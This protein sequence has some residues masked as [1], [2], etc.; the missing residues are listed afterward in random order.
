MLIACEPNARFPP[1]RNFRC[2]SS[3][4][5]SPF[6]LAVAISVHRCHC[7]CGCRM[8]WLVNR[9]RRALKISSIALYCVWS[10]LSAPVCCKQYHLSP[11]IIGLVFLASPA[12]YAFASPMWG[13]IVDKMVRSCLSY[14]LP[15]FLRICIWQL[16]VKLTKT[17]N[18]KQPLC[19]VYAVF[20]CYID[21]KGQ[22]S[23]T[24]PCD[25]FETFARFM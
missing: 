19:T 24:N 10:K 11:A 12:F 4:D 2:H 8:P 15:I 22:L 20:D 14:M 13:W 1:F 21:K 5:V 17:L 6:P 18:N 3:V 23:L 9:H 7:R 16:V 25:A